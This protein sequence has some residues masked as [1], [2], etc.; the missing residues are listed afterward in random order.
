MDVARDDADRCKAAADAGNNEFNIRKKSLF[1][2][3][4]AIMVATYSQYNIVICTD[5]GHDDFQT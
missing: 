4:N 5:Q 3:V 2:A 1:N